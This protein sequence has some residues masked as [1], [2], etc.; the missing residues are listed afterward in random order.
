MNHE[1]SFKRRNRKS[2]RELKTNNQLNPKYDF[3]GTQCSVG[4]NPTDG[5]K[6]IQCLDEVIKGVQTWTM[7]EKN[8]F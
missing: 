3:K 2:T 5:R 7:T 1:P 4:R 8:V 6:R